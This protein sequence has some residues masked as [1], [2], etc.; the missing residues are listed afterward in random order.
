MISG[1]YAI[2]NNFNGHRY[3][4]SSVD[5]KKRWGLHIIRLRKNNHHSPHLQHAWN[6]Y[7]E[8]NFYFIILIE[9]EPR[10]LLDNE[11]YYLDRMSPEYNICPTAGSSLGVIRNDEYRKK[12][13]ISQKG[14][15]IS[16]ET[17]KRISIGMKGKQNSLGIHHDTSIQT[18]EKIK[19]TLLGHVVL[20][21]TRKKISEKNKGYKHTE[22]AKRKIGQ[23]SIGNQYALG[24][25]QSKEERRMRSE[26]QK[27][28]WQREKEYNSGN[29]Y[30]LQY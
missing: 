4:G 17:R 19:R 6:K 14:K 15:I 20:E 2:I 26:S 27:K 12:Q 22:E 11:Q 7:G 13:S 18:K 3:I 29:L 25:I 5:L 9:C 21:K 1:I 28:R 23:A 24:R 16:E 10:Y 30:G 8:N